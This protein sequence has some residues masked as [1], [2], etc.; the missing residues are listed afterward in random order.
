MV[1]ATAGRLDTGATDLAQRLGAGLR[2]LG[3]DLDASQ[4]DRLLRYQAMLA[5]W[6]GVHNLSG[7]RDPDASLEKNLLDCLAIVNPLRQRLG[8]TARVLDVGSGAGLPAVALAIAQPGWS[9]MAAD[10]VAK[11]AAF[12]RQV[13]GEL[14]LSNLRAVHA[15][16]E[17]IPPA[18]GSAF[19]L[20]VSRAVGPLVELVAV[21]RHLVRAD[22]VWVAMK[23]QR[24]QG[25][26]AALPESIEVFHVERIHVPGVDADRCLVWMRARA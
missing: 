14:Q 20:V 8:A 21:S 3:L 16:V 1:V 6:N 13:A 24:P 18:A 7:V 17:Q 5:S 2:A 23:G 26:I 22:G 12:V 10:A 25:E 4:T 11:K 15:R 9:V 19:D